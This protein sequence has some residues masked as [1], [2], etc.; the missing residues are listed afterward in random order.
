MEERDF[1]MTKIFLSDQVNG[2]GI[3]TLPWYRKKL[4]ASVWLFFVVI[5]ILIAR[6]V[7]V[8]T[9]VQFVQHVDP[10]TYVGQYIDDNQFLDQANKGSLP[11]FTIAQVELLLNN[12]VIPNEIKKYNDTHSDG[13]IDH[14]NIKAENAG[15]MIALEAHAKLTEVVKI[16]ALFDSILSALTFNQSRYATLFQKTQDEKM[17]ACMAAYKVDLNTN[18][19]WLNRKDRFLS[20]QINHYQSLNNHLFENA[21]QGL[22][23]S[24][25]A[26]GYSFD[27]SHMSMLGKMSDLGNTL[28]DEQYVIRIKKNKIIHTPFV[29]D[30]PPLKF[31]QGRFIDSLSQVELASVFSKKNIIFLFGVLGFIFAYFVVYWVELLGAKK[32]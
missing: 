1:V 13:A 25:F 11:V 9:N 27:D 19:G 5:G 31:N 10:G 8:G 24:S 7:P 26:K 12:T 20:E 17:V 6:Y 14:Y 23:A 22:I 30:M 15:E 21:A 16:R 4:F 29:S 28:K 3:F 2:K 18:I 32:R